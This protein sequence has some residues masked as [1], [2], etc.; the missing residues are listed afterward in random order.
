MVFA[1][2]TLDLIGT[3]RERAGLQGGSW[4]GARLSEEKIV[5]SGKK[6]C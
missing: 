2:A 3:A 5:F 6:D 4:H 1:A